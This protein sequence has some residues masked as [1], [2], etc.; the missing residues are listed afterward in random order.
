M[1]GG[2]KRG[3]D[4][5]EQDRAAQR[6]RIE[7]NLS[8]AELACLSEMLQ[9]GSLSSNM[10]SE[11]YSRPRVALEATNFGF[12]RGFSMDLREVDP[13]DGQPWDFTVHEKR[14]KAR[15][16]L[17]EEEPI[18]LVGCP[19]CSS[20]SRLQQLSWHKRPPEDYEAMVQ[21]GLTH[22]RF[23]YELY[24]L[25]RSGGRYFLHETPDNTWSL[26][27]DFAQ[28]LIGQE[29]V[30][31]VCGDMCMYGMTSR[32]MWGEAPARKPTAWITNSQC[33]A[34][35]MAIKCD[36][37]HRHV[38]LIGGRA[39]A[40]EVYP[41]GIIHAILRGLRRQM[42]HDNRWHEG[43][44]GVVCDEEPDNTAR[45]EWSWSNGGTWAGNA[46]T[47][48][49]ST[50]TRGGG[51]D[52]SAGNSAAGAGS[53][54]GEVFV[55]QNT[56][57]V[58]DPEAVRRA[59]EDELAEV[60]KHGVWEKVPIAQC[61][62]IT[63]KKPIGVRW[64]DTDKGAGTGKQNIRCRLVA[65]EINTHRDENMFAAM[66]PGEA[67]RLMTSL[68]MSER[69]TR[70]T[71]K[72]AIIDVKRAHF[73]SPATREI[74]VDLPPER[75][76][77]GMCGRLRRSMYGTRD[78][79]YNWEM[80]Y[81]RVLLA[82]GFRQG[83]STPC[84]FIHDE[85]RIR[86]CVHGDDFFIS[87]SQRDI[88]W[89]EAIMRA[90]FEIKDPVIIGPEPGD[91]KVMSVLNRR[92]VWSEN[93]DEVSWEADYRHLDTLLESLRLKGANA[94]STPGVKEKK[95]E[96]DEDTPLEA[97]S[98]TAYRSATMRL[99]YLVADR[100]DIAYAVKEAARQMKEPTHGDMRRVKR[101]VRYLVGVPEAKTIHQR[102]AM[103]SK[104]TVATDS[105]WA[106]CSATRRSTSGGCVHLG[107]HLIKAWSTTQQTLALSSGEAEYMA[108]VKGS[109]VALGVRSLLEDFGV[110]TMPIRLHTDAT[111]GK[112]I[113]TRRGLGKTRHIALHLLWVQQRVQS[114]EIEVH[115]VSTQ[116]N[117]S[118]LFTKHHA[119]PRL[120]FLMERMG[121]ELIKKKD[122]A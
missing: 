71:T 39:K 120:Q 11:I 62:E 5:D 4:E 101:I 122:T 81:T 46:A 36:G 32:D 70:G 21:E 110:G 40:C 109:A 51:S 58:L 30:H 119:A 117:L 54:A 121:V 25:Q 93:G 53:P 37:S 20:F 75:A 18:L 64:V 41:T 118:D 27:T 95:F 63:G 104:V 92:I 96:A 10:V 26:Q 72:L 76:E 42:E 99:A 90:N 31:K 12:E 35:E 80:E 1:R 6:R 111:T 97:A 114:G 102:Q 57:L 8:S 50:A 13:D 34:E 84:I 94:V 85:R 38:T 67:M 113:A 3:G 74:Y 16:R 61:W 77:E 22:H 89:L 55:D 78:A 45:P 14:E 83:V 33:I 2:I 48:A 52:P 98:T 28:D 106:G 9:L 86:V 59:R 112:S 69:N 105:D 7:Q 107:Q 100:P 82:A 19:P 43:E 66:P 73:H 56:G 116:N 29:G 60:D 24:E 79:A 103:P 115:K 68:A 15:R 87:A 88:E 108:I 49:G 23:V 65:K 91:Q 44:I 17:M 47:S